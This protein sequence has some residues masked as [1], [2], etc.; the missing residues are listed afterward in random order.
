MAASQ[1]EYSMLLKLGAQLGRDFGGTFSSAQKILAD[2]QKEVR[3][4]QKAQSDISAYQ[5]HQKSIDALKG[6]VA[7]YERDLKAL[8]EEMAAAGTYD[9]ELANQELALKLKIDNTAATI[10]QKS[11]A[12]HK[13]GVRL[14]EAG[15][16]TA[17]LTKEA[18]RLGAEM[19]DLKG[20]QEK[21]AKEAVSFGEAGRDSALSVGDA[22]AAAGIA[23]LLKG[24]AEGYGECIV[25]AAAYADEIGTVSVQ[26]GIAAEDLQAYYYAAELVDVS[27]ETLT[28]TMARNVRAMAE[29]KDGAA[30]YKEAYETLGVSVTNADGS[31]RDSEEVYWDVIDAL[32]QMENAS[33][34]DAIA[35][36]LLGRSAQQINTLIAAGSG[37][38]DEYTERARQAGYIM[39]EDVLAASMALDDELQIQKKNFEALKNT[40]GAQFAPEITKALQLWNQMLA[41][42]TTFT[43]KHPAAVKGLVT[44]G[45]GLSAI[46][47][48]YGGYVVI[49]KAATVAQ[50]ALNAA[51]SANPIGLAI[52]AVGLLT[53]GVVA[54]TAAEQAEIKATEQLTAASQEQQR[55][56]QALN[57]EYKAICEQY[58]EAS[59]QA[60]ELSWEIDAATAAYEANKQT[61][62]EYR[63]EFE[64]A[65]QAHEEMQAA[66]AEMIREMNL[67]EASVFAL[68]ERLDQLSG[69]TNLSAAS[70]QEM[71]SII[72]K[73]NEEVDGLGLSYDSITKR[74]S[75]TKEEIIALAEVD[76]AGRQYDTYYQML[77]DEVMKRAQAQEL[78]N[79]AIAHK[80]A[81]EENLL[82]IQQEYDAYVAKVNREGR[83]PDDMSPEQKYKESAKEVQTAREQ[84]ETYEKAIAEAS[85]KLRNADRAIEAYSTKLASLN[86]SANKTAASEDRLAEAVA[87]VAQG[88][89][90]AEGAVSY[91]GVD[92]EALEARVEQAKAEQEAFAAALKAVRAGFFG[93]DEAARAYGLTVNGLD[94]YRKITEL[95]DEITAL[96][97]AYSEA[98]DRAYDSLAGQYDIWDKAAEVIP[99][100]IAEINT[101]LETQKAYWHDYGVDLESL[102]A[103]AGDIEGL[104]E[105][106]ASFADGSQ[107]SVNT[108]AGLARASDGELRRMVE[109][110]KAAQGMM[111]GTSGAVVEFSLGDGGELAALQAKLAAEIE[112]FN[113]TAEAEAAAKAT[114]DAY[115]QA[116]REGADEAAAVAREL[117]AQVGTA[118]NQG[119]TVRG[120]AGVPAVGTISKAERV[121]LSAY[122]EG[123]RHAEAGLALVGE[124]GPELVAFGGG[125]RV[126]TAT[127]TQRILA[128]EARPA[129]EAGGHVIT[130]APQF[131][132]Q[133]ITDNNV[134]AKMQEC[135]DTLIDLVVERLE[136]MGMD[137]R[138]SAY[139]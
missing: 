57:A 12:V 95:T 39:E 8:S 14:T 35:M 119:D 101:A 107:D 13:M 110:W 23:A 123:T 91:Y 10:R 108:I 41:G 2:T 63:A 82:R 121:I 126:F 5:K 54:L 45:L 7:E 109:N 100:D 34:R 27:V 122:A 124:Y 130:L 89:M 66:H 104:S 105:I 36:D 77:A 72:R 33:E 11:E 16:D 62:G 44:L 17:S 94:A 58:G 43:E 61:M 49:T 68:I 29:A 20:M 114:M 83:D 113:L 53:A 60:Q 37:V 26:Y 59:Y 87:A 128:P 73:L 74:L 78:Y 111:Q 102:Q 51:M 80:A 42:V 46:V 93:A 3:A 15:V 32:G 117:A 40:I 30:Q 25:G 88:Y 81:E 47:G 127:E 86:G 31:L 120:V 71:L 137:A 84:I 64:A 138:R 21:A 75:M 106:I 96:S 115:I 99:A 50:T 55:E 139:A 118:I 38:M 103:R 132:L 133:G 92:L 135:A 79:T 18:E 19:E 116:L 48:V 90:T 22:L 85:N 67:E 98:Y 129:R 65:M 134:T 136:D 76:I 24:I 70:Q 56:L 52:G 4:L 6:K 9:Q 131:I 97:K 1:R 125:E 69:Q 28:S 112:K